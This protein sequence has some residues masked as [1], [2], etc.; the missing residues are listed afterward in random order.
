MSRYV[1][2][3]NYGA[4][5][6]KSNDVTPNPPDKTPGG[7]TPNNPPS[8]NQSILSN[9]NVGGNLT[10]GNITQTSN[11]GTIPQPNPGN[12]NLD[13]R[14]ININQGNYNENIGGDYIQGNRGEDVEKKQN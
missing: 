7:N 12:I 1:I 9:V 6:K 5:E 2:P 3:L 4:S 11:S 8:N 14:T 10:I 13:N